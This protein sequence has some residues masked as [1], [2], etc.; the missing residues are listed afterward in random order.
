MSSSDTP[1]S[2][3]KSILIV[4]SGVFGLSTTLSLLSRNIYNATSITLL[5]RLQ[6]PAPDASSIDTSRIIRADYSDPFYAQLAATSQER[7]RQQGPNQLGGEGRYTESGLVLVANSGTEGESY[8]RESFENVR[9]M[10]KEAGDEG[11]A[12]DILS[13]KEIFEAA[14]TGGGSGDWGY[15]NRRSGWADAEA[16]MRWLRRQVDAKNRVK[17]EYGEAKS[18]LKDGKKVRGVCLQDGRALHADLVILATG[19]W[20]C[21]LLDLTGIASSTGQTLAYLPI[22]S[23]EQAA[24]EKMPVLLNMST[25]LFIM[26][27]ANKVLKVARHAYGYTNPVKIPNPDSTSSSPFKEDITI[28]LPQTKTDFPTQSIPPEGE[29]ALREALETIIPSLAGRPFTSSRL[30]WYTD[31]PT[32]NFVITYHPSYENLFVATGGSGHGFKFLPVI[33][34]KIVDVVEGRARKEMKEKW[35]WPSKRVQTVVTEDG[36]RGGRVGL[37]LEEEM[38]KGSF[39]AR[40]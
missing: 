23:Q 16:S 37:I 38:R 3:P 24:L 1:F 40:L 11:G 2:P 31:T 21:T 26:P 20:T 12:S 7:W 36:S 8:V 17:Y 10:M 32:G 5:D 34:D 33:G 30:C 15:L 28:S 27:P 14:K 18:I 9:G 19:A 39:V 6:F 29:S 13:P 4:G 25:G 22:T 35:G